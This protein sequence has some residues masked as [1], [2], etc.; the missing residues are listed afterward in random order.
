MESSIMIGVRL[1]VSSHTLIGCA[2]VAWLAFQYIDCEPRGWWEGV[3][4]AI[5]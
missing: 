5:A 2:R 3:P 4:L 1:D